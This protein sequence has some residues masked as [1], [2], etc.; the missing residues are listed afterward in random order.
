MNCML[1]LSVS[2]ELAGIASLFTVGNQCFVISRKTAQNYKLRIRF[3]LCRFFPNVIGALDDVHLE[4][5]LGEEKPHEKSYFCWKQY[6]SI[7]LQVHNRTS[8]C[9]RTGIAYK[10]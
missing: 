10:F 7:H 4:I 5:N 9:M 2:I 8:L 1:M 3:F 6:H